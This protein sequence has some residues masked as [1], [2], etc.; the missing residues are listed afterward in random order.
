MNRLIHSVQKL[1]VF[2]LVAFRR[3]A[4]S[5]I[6]FGSRYLWIFF[7]C[8]IYGF[9]F[10]TVLWQKNIS[11]NGYSIDFPLF[12]LSGLIAARI[13]PFSIRI[14]DDTLTQLKNAGLM[15][16]VLATPSSLWELFV[17]RMLWNCFVCLTDLIAFVGFAKLCIGTPVRPFL[18]S[19]F[20]QPVI[21]MFVAYL[22]IGMMISGLSLFLRRGNSFL[23]TAFFQVS[24][25]FGGVFF[26][27]ELFS[28]KLKL[29]LVVSN[30]LPITHALKTARL[31]LI[32]G[33][34]VNSVIHG[35]ILTVMAFFLAF[36]GFILLKTGLS[37]AKK[38]GEFSKELYN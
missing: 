7:L 24:S 15:E 10:K 9:F 3:D 32:Q 36:L 31:A 25:V 16:W 5:L 28:G 35:Q 19:T 4:Q 23:F 38:N 22:G 33:E 2:T 13:I 18:Q 21:F 27:T 20:V 34:V 14:V 30:S 8:F 1:W 26:P 12:L 11:F 17:S 6:G 37:W 29:L